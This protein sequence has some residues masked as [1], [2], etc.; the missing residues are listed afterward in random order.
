M[1][2][3]KIF[4]ALILSLSFLSPSF[5]ASQKN[6]VTYAPASTSDTLSNDSTTTFDLSTPTS[7][8][9]SDPQMK[10]AAFQQLLNSYFPLTPDQIHAFKNEVAVQQQANAT[11][12]GPS[13]AEGTSS[14]IPVTLKPGGIMPIIRIGQGMITSLVFT[15]AGGK[16]WPITSFSIGDPSSYNVQWDKT[17]GVLMIQGQKLYAQTNIAVMLQ[18][19]TVPVTLNLLIGQKSWDYLDYIQLDQLQPGDPNANGPLPQAPLFLTNLLNGIPPQGATPLNISDSSL[20]QVWSYQG[21]YIMLS[22]ATLLSPAWLS[23]A[24]GPGPT[25]LHA[26]SLPTAPELIV[27]NMGNTQK[28]LVNSDF[29]GKN[30]SNS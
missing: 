2:S 27:S 30:A 10:Q 9:P 15:D 29:G 21:H 20:A 7:S 13:P 22:K 14:I 25:P 26:Y 17:S 5:S 16:V 6:Q 28:L 18:G 19:M 12:P 3:L 1:K 11:P 24:D 23:R 4:P 8:T